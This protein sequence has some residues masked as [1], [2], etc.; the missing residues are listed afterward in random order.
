MPP[1]LAAILTVV[2]LLLVI[3]A[4]P[5]LA[6]AITPDRSRSVSFANDPPTPLPLR[7][8][9][10][11]PEQG[12]K[13]VDGA[14]GTPR[15]AQDRDVTSSSAAG[16]NVGGT[17]PRRPLPVSGAGAVAP[18]LLG[19]GLLGGGLGLLTVV[20]FSGAR[21]WPGRYVRRDV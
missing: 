10:A 6:E 3:N 8:E 14:A 4:L 18:F 17:Q 21:P 16:P 5:M 13:A 15:D 7:P 9:Q 2:G 1:W 19:V 20:G 12:R 11:R